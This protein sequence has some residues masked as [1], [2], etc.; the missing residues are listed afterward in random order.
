MIYLLLHRTHLIF[1]NSQMLRLALHL[2]RHLLVLGQQ[3]FF[4]LDQLQY[5]FHYLLLLLAGSIQLSPQL[6]VL[7]RQPLLSPVGVV[8]LFLLF[9]KL[10]AN[11]PQLELH[12]LILLNS[13]CSVQL[14]PLDLLLERVVC[15]RFAKE[16]LLGL[17]QFLSSPAVALH[18]VLVPLDQVAR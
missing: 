15:V 9:L 7:L 14:H 17:I 3:C 12:L 5:L 1:D 11:I 10:I 8:H 6:L 16:L 2:R 18:E 13:L 4:L